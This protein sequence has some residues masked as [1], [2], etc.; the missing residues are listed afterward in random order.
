[1]EAKRAMEIRPAIATD[2]ERLVEMLGVQL[3]EHGVTLAEPDLARGVEGLLLRPQLGRFL[4]ASE[5]GQIV[6]FAALS[7]L[8]TLEHAGRAAWLDELYVLPESRGRGIG[9]ALLEAAYELATSIGARALDLEIE[10]GH[11]RVA[12]LY[13]RE[14]FRVLSR[15][16]WA[17]PLRARI[18]PA[19]EVH[20]T[21]AEWSGGCL[22]GSIR[23]RI[24]API[25][26]VSHCHCSLC[27]KSTGAPFVTWATV[28][29]EGLSFLAGKPAERASSARA[30][31]SF[32]AACGT[33]LTFREPAR[34]DWID[35]TVGSFDRPQAIEPESHIHVS[36]QLPWVHLDDSLPCHPE[37]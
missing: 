30:I 10:R 29:A 18:S 25:R 1:M 9:R 23:Y 12:R 6:G 20:V 19:R 14:G 26:D 31:R 4:V 34:P 36:S 17:R 33:A 21:G 8:W 28:P 16:R 32:C 27:R 35:V 7:F 15:Q 5:P 3:R 11:E 37:A 22:C 13:E 2:R 24:N